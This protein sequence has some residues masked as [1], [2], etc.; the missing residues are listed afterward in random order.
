MTVRAALACIGV[1]TLTLTTAFL[2]QPSTHS[3]RD[4][5]FP[6][7]RDALGWTATVR[8]AAGQAEKPQPAADRIENAYRASN[9]G[10]ARLEQFDYDAAVTA[11][12]EALGIEASLAA[13]RANLAIALYY[14]GQIDAA[15]E[16]AR[17][18]ERAL[19]KAPQPPYMLGLI[20]KGQNNS[21]E[22]IAAF[23]R[24]L[25]IDPED[26]GSRV[27][28]G[29]VYLQERNV[30]EAL[31]MFREAL[32]REPYNVTAAYGLATTLLRSGEADAGREAMQ[33]FQKLRDSAYGVTYAPGYL[34]QGRNA[35][36]IV[37]TGAEPELVDEATPRVTF[38]DATP[39]AFAARPPDQASATGE[40]L[41]LFDM[42]GDGDQD[43]LVLD[44]AALHLYRND[45]GRF[46]DV[47][48]ATKLD[49]RLPGR[50]VG[51]VAGDYDN[52]GKPDL[53][54][55]RDEGPRLL[56]QRADGAFE[57]V[58]GAAL[59]SSGAIAART[60]AFADVD[61]DGDLDIVIAG[62]SVPQP[63]AAQQRQR[64][65][66]RY[67]IRGGNGRSFSPGHRH[68]PDRLRQPPG[69]RSSR[70]ERGP[71]ADAVPEHA[72]RHLPRRRAGCRACGRRARSRGGGRRR[73]QGWLSPISL[74]RAPA[75]HRCSR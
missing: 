16:E 64:H 35:E 48:A 18:A 75:S 34:Q 43:L 7:S 13:A 44:A 12:R 71:R 59:G 42:D 38:A 11:F 69:H 40:R 36:A 72:R 22:A 20:A 46:T 19:P 54:V 70:R 74:S 9:R 66:H 24:A 39:P 31:P 62:T 55:L 63:A 17:A 23:R 33:Q 41:T 45:G 1:S 30:K 15:Q 6:S 53:F 52:D 29:Q 32:A 65:V 57:D 21:D 61:H 50:G 58:T 3:F 60:A 51:A 2:G 27:N 68:R 73:E 10:V 28:L 37:S 5:R 14:A 25:Q 4:E 26:V 56:H 67:R 8:A 49:A 47:T